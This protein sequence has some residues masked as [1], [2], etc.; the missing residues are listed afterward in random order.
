M[1]KFIRWNSQ[2][3]DVWAGKYAR[4]KFVD[5]GGRKT[6]YIEQGAGDPVIL[7]HG[8][9][10][11]SYLWAANIDVLAEK[12]KVYALDLHK[13]RMAKVVHVNSNS[14]HYQK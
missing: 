14:E 11:D 1:S 3:L 9:F 8:F 7:L 13:N 4:G 12:F 5:L 6:H 10:Y 2:P